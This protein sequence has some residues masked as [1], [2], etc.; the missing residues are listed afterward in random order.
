MGKLLVTNILW[1]YFSLDGQTLFKAFL[2]SEFCEENI[3]VW[4]AIEDYRNCRENKL[5][6]KARRIYNEFIIPEAP[7][8][9]NKN[10]A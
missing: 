5:K 7:K 10:S 6:S 8:E 2:Q 1:S 9:V 4:I 3:E